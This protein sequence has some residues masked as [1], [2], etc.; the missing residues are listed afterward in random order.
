[1]DETPPN[2]PQ[3]HRNAERERE[4]AARLM[5]SP[6]LRRTPS[7]PQ[8]QRPHI[9][10]LLFNP[11]PASLPPAPTQHQEDPFGGIPAPVP[12]MVQVDLNGQVLRLTQGIAA[13]LAGTPTNYTLPAPPN[14]NNYQHLPLALREQMAQL[15]PPPPPVATRGRRRAAP[16]P[17][18][19]AAARVGDQVVINMPQ[20]RRLAPAPLL[21][22]L[23]LPLLEQMQ[24]LAPPAPPPGIRGR[25]AAPA[26]PL[27]APAPVNPLP[28]LPDWL[29]DISP[30][31]TPAPTP[32]PVPEM[33][34]AP[35]PPPSHT[36]PPI[37][38]PEVHQGNIDDA[39]DDFILPSGDA[40][41]PIDEDSN[42]CK[43]IDLGRMSIQ[44]PSCKALH[45]DAERLSKSSKRNP[46]FGTCCLQGKIQIPL[47]QP[48]PRELKELYDGTS[49][50]SA[51]FLKHNVS[52]NNAFAMVSLS[53]QPV[54]LGAGVP[55]FTIQGEL[56]HLHG[57]LLPEEGENA[58]WAQVYFVTDQQAL[59]LRMNGRNGVRR[60]VMQTL[61]DLLH[62]HH[63]Y[64][65]HYKTAYEQLLENPDIPDRSFR[66]QFKAGTDQRRYNLPTADEVAIILP[67]DGTEK[68]TWRDLIVL[69][70]IKYN[71][72]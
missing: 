51:H 39:L 21:P 9:Q 17:L 42:Y 63:F 70:T 52:Y 20:A 15:A 49:P 8:I 72:F 22:N 25:R 69:N 5:G 56:R 64:I 62:R 46:K 23:P 40:Y 11:R 66:L 12:Q 28:Q 61:Q 29:L 48:L 32:V 13:R 37:F 43:R 35:S 65:T 36:P 1:M 67:G 58:K 10:P 55:H 60:D 6:E 27:Q 57:T 50:N 54:N 45:W 4:R 33:D 7:T 14:P 30:V 26:P 38:N 44:C 16:A 47:L 19:P 2:S 31:T 24:Q 34:P 59:N 71:G 41:R 68:V 18:P 3:R 53:A